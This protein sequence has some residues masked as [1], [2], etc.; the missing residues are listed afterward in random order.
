MA[1]LVQN[2]ELGRLISAIRDNSGSVDPTSATN[3]GILGQE[4]DRT[5]QEEQ[6]ELEREDIER[7]NRTN[8]RPRGRVALADMEPSS[9]VKSLL[10]QANLAY[11]H[12]DTNEAVRIL[13]EI[14]RIEPNTKPAWYTLSS[15]HEDLGNKDK[16]IQLRIVVTHL[17]RSNSEQ[18]KELG[19]Q[20]REMGLSEQA[21]YCYG[22]AVR[23]DRTD[24]EA[25]WERALLL[26][27]T[28]KLRQAVNCLLSILK[29]DPH[30]PAIL[31]E[32]G[33]IYWQ[34]QDTD[35]AIQLYVSALDYW[36]TKVP[37]PK[38]A[39]QIGGFSKDELS[40]LSDLYRHQ[41]RYRDAARIIVDGQ[42]WLQGR[43]QE[44][45]T[46]SLFG[47]DRE[48]DAAR[49]T[50][51]QWES[52]PQRWVEEMPIHPLDDGLRLRL[53]LSR[54]WEGRLEEAKVCPPHSARTFILRSVSFP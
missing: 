27:D 43:I 12:G 39:A 51:P 45:P 38:T 5:M 3:R 26:R 40:I 25:Q 7:R 23:A 42:R 28:G 13:T 9:E 41:R 49:K 32:I 8:K 2:A 21:I 19:H 10:G 24:A 22:Q 53:G 37:I 30:N 16:A 35:S 47:D 33:P 14:I 15:I 17:E 54:L 18:W 46:W 31:R 29:Q 48:F 50:R 36:R 44:E 20:S 6:N 4:W 34:L 11:V 52:H 1:I